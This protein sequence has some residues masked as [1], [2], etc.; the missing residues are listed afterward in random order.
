MGSKTFF[1]ELAVVLGVDVERGQHHVNVAGGQR[2]GAFGPVVDDLEGDLQALLRKDGVRRCFQSAVGHQAAHASHP[3]VHGHADLG[4]ITTGGRGR[5]VQRPAGINLR[6]AALAAGELA[7]VEIP[8][9][10]EAEANQ[11]QADNEDKNPA[12]FFNS[13]GHD[14]ISLSGSVQE[15]F[16]G[17][18]P[19]M[20]F[21]AVAP[22][23]E[24]D[25][26]SPISILN[27]FTNSLACNF[28]ASSSILIFC[29]ST[30]L[31]AISMRASLT[32]VISSILRTISS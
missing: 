25:E 20:V 18:L 17:S 23:P 28:C 22:V 10:V 27:C 26:A 6:A 19:P 9:S 12:T 2:G 15:V 16:C 24:L 1:L 21:S 30:L 5:K 13:H 14:A 3:H 8:I 32:A 31:M 29:W 11:G 7:Q 4:M